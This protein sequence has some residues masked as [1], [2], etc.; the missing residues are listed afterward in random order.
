MPV[1]GKHTLRDGNKH[2]DQKTSAE[3]VCQKST[4]VLTYRNTKINLS[5]IDHTDIYTTL[6]QQISHKH[7]HTS[8]MNLLMNL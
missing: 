6:T 5:Q 2:R 8:T 4:T 1:V 7:I 3:S